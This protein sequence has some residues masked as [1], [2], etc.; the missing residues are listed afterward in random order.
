[1]RLKFRLSNGKKTFFQWD[2]NQKIILESHV[3]NQVHFEN[4]NISDKAYVKDVYVD[5]DGRS[6][7]DVPDIFLQYTPGFLIYGYI[8]DDNGNGRYTEERG[9]ISVIRRAKPSDYVFTPEDQKTLESAFADA[10]KYTPEDRTDEERAQARENIGAE[11]VANKADEINDA[12]DNT[13]YPTV[14]AVKTGLD[15]K[16]DNPQSAAVGEVL[17][18]EE[19]DENGKPTKWKTAPAAAEQV[20]ADWQDNDETAASYVKNRPFSGSLAK[21]N[22]RV[23]GNIIYVVGSN[24]PLWTFEIAGDTIYDV[25]NIETQINRALNKYGYTYREYGMTNSFSL[26]FTVNEDY[27]NL[28]VNS[29]VVYSRKVDKQIGAIYLPPA[30]SEENPGVIYANELN[31]SLVS[32]NNTFECK[33]IPNAYTVKTTNGDIDYPKLCVEKQIKTYEKFDFDTD[34][35]SGINLFDYAYAK[36]NGTAGEALGLTADDAPIYFYAYSL[37]YDRFPPSLSYYIESATGR[38]FKAILKLNSTLWTSFEEISSGSGIETP[39][40]ISDISDET[41]MVDNTDCMKGI[42]L[43]RTLSAIGGYENNRDNLVECFYDDAD[44]MPH[45]LYVRKDTQMYDAFDWGTGNSSVGSFCIA[46]SVGTAGASLGLTSDDC[47]ITFMVLSAN[48]GIYTYYIESATNKRFIN[49]WQPSSAVREWKS[50]SEIDTSS[51]SSSGTSAF[52][53]NITSSTDDNDNV[54]YSADKTADE[55]LAAYDSGAMMFAVMDGCVFTSDKSTSNTNNLQLDFGKFVA[56]YSEDYNSIVSGHIRIMVSKTSES[57]N[58]IYTENLYGDIFFIVDNGVVVYPSFDLFATELQTGLGFFIIIGDGIC[59]ALSQQEE[60]D[61]G[62]VFKF[63]DI[64]N[65]KVHIITANM[66]SSTLTYSEE[67]LPTVPATLPNPN[68]LTFTGAVSGEYDGSEAVTIDI[69]QGGGNTT[70]NSLG[71]SSATVGQIA[72]ITAVDDNGKPTAWESVNLPSGGDDEWKLIASQDVAEDVLSV[73]LP[74]NNEKELMILVSL[75]NSEATIGNRALQVAANG[76]NNKKA[77]SQ[78]ANIFANTG[79]R[80]AKIHLQHI[81]EQIVWDVTNNQ[82]GNGV[83]DSAVENMFNFNSGAF[84]APASITTIS[85]SSLNKLS[86]YYIGAGSKIRVFAIKE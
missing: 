36:E 47:P 82:G 40:P 32:I 68:K 6:V 17:T 44:G 29:L 39:I 72:K 58:V 22:V 3:C 1:M 14:G 31:T 38:R 5:G 64:A 25:P 7:V 77:T 71:I 12:G 33:L 49:E 51:G 61:E 69:P 65:G 53:I 4:K 8:I 20:Q 67:D 30:R 19:I 43:A 52:Y 59:Y 24:S 83:V 18:V 37:S 56:T 86:G 70:D 78:N 80:S 34:C 75:V 35:L 50:I 45:K 79:T 23:S 66:N 16:I 85:V 2:V 13:H 54:T 21:V 27:P 57:V 76:D 81:G 28:T 41:V 42:F 63:N 46:K 55:I 60:N 15:K 84:T 9:D 74:I 48:R 62:L 73:E 10:V 11:S 26:T